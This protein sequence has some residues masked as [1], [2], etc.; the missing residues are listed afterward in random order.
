MI[1]GLW[2]LTF[3]MAMRD[4]D[5]AVD[6]LWSKAFSPAFHGKV[7]TS[8]M[9]QGNM[10]LRFWVYLLCHINKLF[11]GVS[12]LTWILHY[13]TIAIAEAL[14]DDK[15]LAY[16][17]FG[18]LLSQRCDIGWHTW[19]HCWRCLPF[20]PWRGGGYSKQISI[21]LFFW[22]FG[23][24]SNVIKRNSNPHSVTLFDQKRNSGQSRY[25]YST[26]SSRMQRRLGV[27]EE[28][29]LNQVFMSKSL[30]FTLF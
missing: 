22:T 15:V 26:G 19:V 1:R 16:M 25:P 12:P 18:I 21:I 17:H 7:P 20:V 4:E 27:S 11:F 10:A 6:H 30:D 24:Y 28:S 3:F 8:P 23:L 29:F 9:N 13:S 2:Y 14:H 5:S